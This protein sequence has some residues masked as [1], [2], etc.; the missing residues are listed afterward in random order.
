MLLEVGL[1]FRCGRPVGAHIVPVKGRQM[2]MFYLKSVLLT[3]LLMLCSAP[4]LADDEEAIAETDDALS[5]FESSAAITDDELNAH[6]AKEELH[7]D[8]V[9]VND[10]EQDGYLID[11][12]AEDNV[13]G[14]NRITDGSFTNAS[15]FFSTVQNTGN[16]VLIQHST[17]I[18]VDVETTP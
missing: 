5:A 1:G 6:R 15:G 9:T 10:Q 11:N 18:N 16:N 17:V 12:V 13:T 3:V 7:V 2:D 4:L 14:E 8:Q